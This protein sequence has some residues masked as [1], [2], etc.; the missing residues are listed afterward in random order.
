[1]V[2]CPSRE[3]RRCSVLVLSVLTVASV[4]CSSASLTSNS[5]SGVK[6]SIGATASQGTVAAGGGPVVVR[7]ATT[8]ECAWTVSKDAPWIDAV[9]PASGQGNGEVS[10]Q[11]MANP[12]QTSRQTVLRIND[13]SLALRQE[14]A[15]PPPPPAAAPAPTPNPSPAPTP[16]PVPAPAPNPQPAP[17]PT[18]N[19]APPPEQSRCSFSITP[20][21]HS[22]PSRGGAGFL[23]GVMTNNGCA[24]TSESNA[25]S[26][27][28]IRSG[29]TGSGA[30]TVTFEVK[31]NRDDARIG[32]LTVAGRTVTVRQEEEEEEEEEEDD[33]DDKDKKGKDKKDD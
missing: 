30:G 27:I 10:V 11:V 26:W 23:V 32:T 20:S 9:S 1:M 24:W 16:D 29:Q 12:A 6:C 18:P 21:S 13:E 25:P 8:P 5:P 3:T 22:A 2:S 15:S 28:A 31:E 19:P 7:I 14:A 17:A 4:A 33:D